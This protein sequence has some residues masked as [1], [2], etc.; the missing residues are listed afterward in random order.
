MCSPAVG[1]IELRRRNARVY[2]VLDGQGRHVGNVQYANGAWKFKAIGYEADG[3]VIPGGGPLTDRHDAVVDTP[4]AQA[5]ANRLGI[6]G[7]AQGT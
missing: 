7:R 3:R 1:P 6:G 2:R 4:E 5:L